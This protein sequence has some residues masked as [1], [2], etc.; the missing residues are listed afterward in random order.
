MQKAYRPPRRAM[1]FVGVLSAMSLGGCE[2]FIDAAIDCIDNDRPVLSPNILPDPIL[3]QTYSE[4]IQVSIRNEPRD[5]NFDF[6]FTTTGD[7]PEGIQMESSGRDFR[8][9]GTPIELGDF[10]FSV[11]VEVRGTPGSFNDTS[12]LCLTVDTNSYQWSIQIT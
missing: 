3:N 4:L 7:L 1:L 5:D 11:R 2:F 9:F 10:S 8:L 6:L 12:G